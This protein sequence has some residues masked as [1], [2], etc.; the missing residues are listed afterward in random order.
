MGTH[1]EPPP[2]PPRLA[3]P[4][5]VII[6]GLLSWILATIVV[7]ASGDSLS[8]YVPLCIAG[9]GVAAFGG[10]I[11]LLQRRSVRRGDRSAQSGL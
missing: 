11:F 7:V 10:I 1:P 5:P 4:R 6:V 2:L 8:H 3:D 9:L